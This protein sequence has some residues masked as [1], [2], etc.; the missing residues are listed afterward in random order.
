MTALHRPSILVPVLLS[1]ACTPASKES[2]EKPEPEAR[3]ESKPNAQ[4]N[5]D[6]PT[7]TPITSPTPESIAPTTNEP[8]QLNLAAVREGPLDLAVWADQPF[9]LLNGEPVPIDA[10]GRPQPQPGALAGLR[11]RRGMFAFS[12]HTVAFGGSLEDEAW[13]T[14][15]QEHER[16]ASEYDSYVREQ[17]RWKRIASEKGPLVEFYS[18]IVAREGGVLGLRAWAPNPLQDVFEGEDD[19]PEARAFHKKLLAAMDAA[20]QGFVWLGSA[21]SAALPKLP[22]EPLEPF[23]ATTTSD[24]TLYVLARPTRTG[25]ARY[26]FDPERD[27][28]PVLLVWPPGQV[29]PQTVTLPNYAGRTATLVSSGDVALVGSEGADKPYLA[30]GRGTSW[31]QVPVELGENQP[32]DTTISSIARSPVGQ[33][34]VVFGTWNMAGS[35]PS[36]TLWTK[37]VDGEWTRVAL[38]PPQGDEVPATERWVW[39]HEEGWAKLSRTKPSPTNEASASE[40]VWARGAVWV[41]AD[42]GDLWAMDDGLMSEIRR[43][44]LYTTMPISQPVVLEPSDHTLLRQIAGADQGKAKPGSDACRDFTLVLGD[45]ALAK[46][47]SAEQ[48]EAIG[49]AASSDGASLLELYVGEVEGRRELVLAARAYDEKPAKALIGAVTKAAGLEKPVVDCKPRMLVEMVEDYI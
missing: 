25:E 28:R 19:G 44:A 37:P 7:A 13:I 24:G 11:P 6:G 42:V 8:S 32:R 29:D 16:A 43:T 40:V 15:V 12:F 10:Q 23:T 33:L 36:D 47:I 34:W 46:S 14:N 21:N 27:D 48:R 1:L 31:E 39:G 45:E 26:E 41:V 9:V 20:P 3:T 5:T 17:G 49:R 35:G 22:S 38:A 2:D 18:A 30:M 4:P